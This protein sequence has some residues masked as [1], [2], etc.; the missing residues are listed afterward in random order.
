MAD[1]PKER[2]PSSINFPFRTTGVDHLRQFFIRATRV[3]KRFILLV[4]CLVT[5]AIHIEITEKL[6]TVESILAIRN[7]FAEEGSLTADPTTQQPSS[8]PIKTSKPN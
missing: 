7:L 8:L 6:N 2:L 3:E 1:L 5:R 4:T